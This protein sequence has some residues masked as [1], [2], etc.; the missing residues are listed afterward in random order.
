V[1]TTIKVEA[2]VFWIVIASILPWRW[3]QYDPPKRW[4]YP[5]TAL[6][7]ATTQKTANS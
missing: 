5:S 3:R 2:V 6:H 1:F 7:G 4:Y